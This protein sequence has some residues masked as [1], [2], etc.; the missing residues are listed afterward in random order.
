[1]DG[2]SERLVLMLSCRDLPKMDIMSKTDA[3]IVVEER[4]D[5]QSEWRSLVETEV[6]MNTNDPD[7]QT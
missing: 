6:V 2:P 1:M 4:P 3:Y 5:M 7:F